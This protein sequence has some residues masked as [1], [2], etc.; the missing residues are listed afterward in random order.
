VPCPVVNNSYY[1]PLT[2]TTGLSFPNLRDG[3]YT[4]WSIYRMITDSTGETN[5]QKLV[6]EAQNLVD[7]NIP[8]FVPFIPVCAT[9]ASGL[10]DPGLDVYREHFVPSTIETIPDTVTITPNDGSLGSTVTC[11]VI[12]ATLPALTLGGGTEAGGDVGGIIEGPFTKSPTYPGPTE[13]QPH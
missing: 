6:T 7:T 1:C 13:G 3:K 11:R 5:A 2:P 4:A 8:D 9:S 10:N 12:K